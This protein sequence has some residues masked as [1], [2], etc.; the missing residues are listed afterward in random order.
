MAL[1]DQMIHDT[2][3]LLAPLGARRYGFNPDKCAKEGD[4]NDLI[5]K[6]DMAYELGE[7]SYSSTSFTAI[8]QDSKIVKEDGIYVIGKELEDIVSDGPFARVTIIIFFQK[9]HSQ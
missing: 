1:F 6:R 8:T 2:M 7:G 5:L 3:D 9:S 4:P